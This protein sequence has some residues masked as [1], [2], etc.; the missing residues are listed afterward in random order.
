MVGT[1][2]A[3]R[4]ASSGG[5]AAAPAAPKPK[6]SPTPTPTPTPTPVP[7]PSPT[8]PNSDNRDVYFGWPAA[9]AD[10]LLNPSAVT[11][12]GVFVFSVIARNDDNQTLTH[13]RLAFGGA[14]EPG[15]PT[16]NGLPAGASIISA[17]V[18]GNTCINGTGEPTALSFSCDL[19]NFASGDSVTVTFTIQAGPDPVDSTLWASFKVAEKVS[20]QGANQNTAFASAP[21]T[22]LTTGSDANGTFK[23]DNEALTLSTDLAGSTN[24]KQKTILN[25][26]GGFG[27]VI[28]I[29]ETDNPTGCTP[30]CIG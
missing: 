25:V 27:G 17:V 24:D 14:A 29:F 12:D 9:G 4:L 22:I 18:S 2:S 20:D 15:G 30:S 1:T 16:A 26:P 5:G 28:S 21:I 11:T 19:P 3:S 23:F 6:P 10:G 7:T 8:P 13:P